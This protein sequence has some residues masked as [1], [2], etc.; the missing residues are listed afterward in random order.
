MN[1]DQTT[2]TLSTHVILINIRVRAKNEISVHK[3]PSRW[4]DLISLCN[5]L[6]YSTTILKNHPTFVSVSFKIMCSSK[7]QEEWHKEHCSKI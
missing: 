4:N 5:L 6:K 3:I 7:M 2:M 1:T